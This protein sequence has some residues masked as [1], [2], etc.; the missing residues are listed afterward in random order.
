MLE[1][2]KYLSEESNNII[3]D[4]NVRA[5]QIRTAEPIKMKG[6]IAFLD[7]LGW[8]GIWKDDPRALNKINALLLELKAGSKMIIDAQINKNS[9]NQTFLEAGWK[10][11]ENFYKIIGAAD[12]I[13]IIVKDYFQQ[14]LIFISSVVNMLINNAAKEGIYL[15]GAISYGDFYRVDGADFYMGEAVDDASKWHESCNWIGVLLTPEA[16]KRADVQNLIF[17]I[18][19][20]KKQK[21]YIKYNKI[22][23]KES[24]SKQGILVLNYFMSRE[25]FKIEEYIK[26]GYNKVI[27]S[28]KEKSI[29]DKYINTLEFLKYIDENNLIL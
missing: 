14:G 24:Y 4:L 15:R 11:E 27:D 7:V 16:S 18:T 25:Y 19:S 10:K 3:K 26:K 5:T 29:I 23:L 20:N 8:K 13:V 28:Q 9:I 1:F 22:P 21:T 17:G 6:Y 12:T 2:E